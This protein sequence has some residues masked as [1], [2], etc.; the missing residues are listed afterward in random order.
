LSLINALTNSARLVERRVVTWE[1][2]GRLADSLAALILRTRR[3]R[4]DLVIGVL[5]GGG[6]LALVVADRLR[7]RVDFLNVKSY[8]GVGERAGPRVLST[9]IE[10]IEN[11]DVLL[12]DDLVDE[13][14]TMSFAVE[15][16]RSRYSPRSIQ[17][18]SLFV[19]P[20]S[21]FIPDYYLGSVREWVIFPWELCE[22][23][24]EGCAPGE[25]S[26]W[27]MRAGWR[28]RTRGS[29]SISCSTGG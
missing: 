21:R 28:A 13:G 4:H 8:T 17:T 29:W 9:I 22:F 11:K 7:V 10:D 23:G 27:R 12:V 19:K 20:W 24:T 25:V 14:A 15:F 5:R 1:E 18:S 6:P 26:R 16:L 2:F 3:V